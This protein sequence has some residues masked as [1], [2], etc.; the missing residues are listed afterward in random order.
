M[1]TNTYVYYRSVYDSYERLA[2]LD[3]GTYV[4]TKLIYLSSTL[5]SSHRQYVLIYFMFYF[6]FEKGHCMEST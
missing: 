4:S 2:R 3:E 5:D 1:H 6:Y